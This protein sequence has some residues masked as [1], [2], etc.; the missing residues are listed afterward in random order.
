[1][2]SSDVLRKFV[3]RDMTSHE[4]RRALDELFRS[5]CYGYFLKNLRGPDILG[6]AD[7]LDKVS[8]VFFQSTQG[9]HWLTRH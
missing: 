2:S 1:M 7:F 9:S 4:S 5:P 6:Y 8:T 3:E